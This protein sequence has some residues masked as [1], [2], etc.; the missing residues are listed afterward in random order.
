M[1]SPSQCVTSLASAPPPFTLRDLLGCPQSC[2]APSLCVS[3]SRVGGSGMVHPCTT[4]CDLCGHWFWI[5]RH[6]DVTEQKHICSGGASLPWWVAAH[7]LGVVVLMSPFLISR[8]D[9]ANATNPAPCSKSLR[10]PK[11][12]MALLHTGQ[13]KS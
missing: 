12:P 7:L 10:L 6:G 13:T 1:T 3:L 2:S 9:L 11:P 5:T 4:V 8:V